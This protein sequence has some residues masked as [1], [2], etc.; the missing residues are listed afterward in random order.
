MKAN[1]IILFLLSF[2]N[3]APFDGS[4]E[5][6]YS[7]LKMVAR[8]TI[9]KKVPLANEIKDVK[10]TSAQFTIL[11]EEKDNID[12]VSKIENNENFPV[13]VRDA[14]FLISNSPNYRIT[15]NFQQK[16]NEENKTVKC[17]YYVFISYNFKTSEGKKIIMIF[18]GNVEGVISLKKKYRVCDNDFFNDQNCVEKDFYDSPTDSNFISYFHNYLDAEVCRKVKGKFETDT[19]YLKY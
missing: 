8:N 11:D 18:D 6:K 16:E 12:S 3:S 7:F 14:A 9:K 15:D 19:K 2:I 5:N 13:K 17:S 1:I 4:K 10:I